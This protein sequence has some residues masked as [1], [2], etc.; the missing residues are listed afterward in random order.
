MSTPLLF[1]HSFNAGDLITILPGVQ[2]LYK[3]TNKKSIILQRLDLPADYSH[4]NNHP[5]KDESGKQVC[6]NL[7]MF[8]MLKPLIESQEYVESFEIWGGE[9]VDFDIDFTRMHSQMP[10]PGGQIQS[11]PTLIFPQ[12]ECD[13]SEKWLWVWKEKEWENFVVINRTERYRNPFITYH[14]LKPYE[15]NIKFVGTKLEHEFFCKEN[16]L[17]VNYLEV[18]NFYELAKVINSCKFFIGNQSM[19]WHISDAM[20]VKRILEVC[21]VFPN[22]FPTGDDGYSFISQGALE[23]RFNELMK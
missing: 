7:T 21:T 2:K 18:E 6:M 16:N 10:L 3:E 23:Y 17:E 11:W 14:F 4:N 5:I 19:C 15:K 13:L 8:K 12:L 20:K 22:T 9:K 1:K